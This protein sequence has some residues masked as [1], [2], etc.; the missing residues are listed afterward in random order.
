MGMSPGAGLAFM[1]AGAVS[2]IP[3]ALAVYALVRRPVFVL[4]IAM[5][6]VGS[7]AAGIAY[8]LFV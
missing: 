6:F 8:T 3:A 1:T 2:S 5:G 4:Y 7:V